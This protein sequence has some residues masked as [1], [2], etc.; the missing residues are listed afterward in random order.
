[1]KGPAFNPHQRER[2]RQ[3]DRE[4]ERKKCMISFPVDPTFSPESVNPEDTRRKTTDPNHHDQINQSKQLI[5]VRFINCVHGLPP[6]KAGF[7]RSA[8]DMRKTR[9]L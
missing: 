4:T 5:K 3:R 9:S 2:Q 8:L 1:V 7:K 6:P